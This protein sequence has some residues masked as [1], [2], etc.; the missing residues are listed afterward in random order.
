MS[1]IKSWQVVDVSFSLRHG[2]A[3]SYKPGSVEGMPYAIGLFPI[4]VPG[5][6]GNITDGDRPP[7][8]AFKL[9]FARRGVDDKWYWITACAGTHRYFC[10]SMTEAKLEP[11]VWH[12]FELHQVPT[13]EVGVAFVRE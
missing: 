11:G 8:E 2:E 6:L 3:P 7:A 10:E 12:G 4:Q 9:A 5:P 1:L 13:G